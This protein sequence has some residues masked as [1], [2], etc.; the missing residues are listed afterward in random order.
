VKRLLREVSPG[1]RSDE[2]RRT[3]GPGAAAT[4]SLLDFLIGEPA[5]PEGEVPDLGAS[6]GAAPS[7]DAPAEERP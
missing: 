6:D 1:G 4:R 3:P 2:R 7:L 5:R